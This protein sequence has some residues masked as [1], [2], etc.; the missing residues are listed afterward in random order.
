M[1]ELTLLSGKGGTGKTTMAAAF[2][3][4]ATSKVLADCDVDAADLHLLLQPSLK[5][6]TDFVG[7]QAPRLDPSLCARCGECAGH[8]R[9]DAILMNDGLPEFDLQA[10]EGCSLCSR[11]CP[12]RAISMHDAVCGEILFSH[13]PFGPLVHAK[14]GIG[15]DNSGKL[16]TLVRREARKRAQADQ[17]SLILIDGPPGVGCPVTAAITGVDLVLMVTEPTLSGI[18][19]LKRVSELCRHFKIPTLVCI[20]KFDVNLENT[21][22]L[23]AYCRSHNIPIVGEIPLEPL[24]NL[25][26]VAKKSVVDYPCGAVSNLV[27]TIWQQ[28]NPAF[29]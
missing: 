13:T 25:A 21:E 14:L 3:S 16:V 19:D 28:V 29:S 2:A 23:R 18:H 27:R 8:C 15:E 12:T 22:K 4:L 5:R 11:V 9:Y 6:R 26:Q 7:G 17:A 10:C 1:K 24:V 20:N